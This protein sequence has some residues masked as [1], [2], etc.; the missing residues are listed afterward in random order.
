MFKKYLLTAAA[1]LC[2]FTSS[3][4]QDNIQKDSVP[5]ANGEVKNRNVMLNASADNQP[6]QISIGLPAEMSATIYEDGTPVS[7]TWWPMLPYFYWAGSPMYSRMGVSSLSENAITNGAINYS[8]DCWSRE[9]G[10]KFEGHADYDTNIF[11]LQR[12]DVSLAGPLAKGWSYAVSAYVNHDPGSNHLA[13]VDLQNNMKQFKAGVT[14]HFSG[15]KGKVSL[16]YKYSSMTDKSD[17]NGPFY[18]VGDGSVRQLDGFDLG[19]DG[20]MPAD[21][22]LTYMGMGQ[23][24]L[25]EQA[26]YQP[27]QQPYLQ[28]PLGDLR[29]DRLYLEQECLLLPQLRQPLQPEGSQREHFFSR[30]GYRHDAVQQLSDGRFLY[31][32]FHG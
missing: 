19:K 12:F 4:A 5:N 13:D 29:R 28:R 1:G 6:R 18:Y 27:Y 2:V 25:P 11:G 15:S 14:K 24:P 23:L 20:Y 9:G 8:V 21:Q 10:K 32:S 26:V 7:W 3:V 31:P 30:S 17:A 22:E 16:F